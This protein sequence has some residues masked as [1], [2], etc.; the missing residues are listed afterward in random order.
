MQADMS[1]AIPSTSM[2]TDNCIQ[3]EGT[4]DLRIALTAAI[5]VNKHLNAEIERLL[6]RLEK[7]EGESS[8]WQ[9]QAK[10][11]AKK[12]QALQREI[13]DGVGQDEDE[14]IK[15][16]LASAVDPPEVPCPFM[17]SNLTENELYRM[18]L[19]R[20]KSAGW[21]I[22]INELSLGHVLGEG[23][24]GTTYEG[25]WRGAKV[26]V[27]CVR[28]SSET[29]MTNFLREIE[30]LSAVRHPH[31]VPF[32]G[33]SIRPP[34]SFW[35]ISE[36]MPGGTLTTWLHGQKGHMQPTR[37]LLDRVA[38][39]LEVAR[40]M[41][42]L[43]VC[44]PPILHRDLKPSNVFIDGSGCARIGDFGLARRLL[45]SSCASLTGETGTYLYM[46]PE[47][48]RH[49][50][51]DSK[52]DV[53]SWG[54][55]YVECLTTQIPYQ[56]TFLT[57]VQIAIAVSEERLRPQIPTHLYP[58]LKEFA[59]MALEFNPD[60]RP[61]F[62]FIVTELADSLSKMQQQGTAQNSYVGRL[63]TNLSSAW[64]A[65]FTMGA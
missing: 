43:E 11:L 51:Y 44:V 7:S 49:D 8:S 3:L 42:G 14:Q 22:D 10:F 41:Q 32:L 23:A 4:E 57:P 54:V 52:T 39:A 17:T 56:N 45:P 26:A 35:L 58:D 65:V 6:I 13:A 29:E 33:A 48:I 50:V 12:L 34:D 30:T 46:S 38:K 5:A 16:I 59:R 61:S 2:Q 1:C 18:L 25:Q 24:F 40:G 37:S 55:L 15:T 27:K 47:M 19:E 64:R 20:G 53:W 28:I 60:V 63:Q 62:S 31:V 9:R 21:L 36:F